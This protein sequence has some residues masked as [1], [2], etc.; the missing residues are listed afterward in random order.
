M[1]PLLTFA[2]DVT[3][4]PADEYIQSVILQAQIRVE[5]VRRSYSS[6]EK[7]RLR[8]L[9]GRPEDWGRTLH[10]TFWTHTGTNVPSF[11]GHTSVELSVPCT[12]DLN[13][14]STKYFYGLDGGGEIPLIF[15]FSGTVF[16]ERDERILIQ[17]ISWEKESRFRM[18]AA[19]WKSLMDHHYPASAWM[20][21]DRD[22]FDRLYAFK[23]RNSIATWDE[24]VSRL[25]GAVEEEEVA[26]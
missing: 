1:T 10:D 23:R 7:E 2:L 9:F 4:V 17:R 18:P 24:A 21:L 20:M 11:R 15:L 19:T 5:S 16:Y 25:L 26:A 3:N 22:V 12:F 14:A 6:E 13:V 8:E